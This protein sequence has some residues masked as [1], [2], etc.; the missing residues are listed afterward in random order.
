QHMSQQEMEQLIAQYDK[1]SAVR[2][3]SGPMKW[4][5]F[6]LLVLFSVYQLSSS[7]FFTL[8]PQIHRPIHLA[9]GLGL[10][11]LLYAGRS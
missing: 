6:V 11:F 8:P 2:Q 5:T 3:L 7:L 10:V 4:I 9:F 1:E